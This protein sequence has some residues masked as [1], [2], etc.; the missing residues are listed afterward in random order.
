MGR[1]RDIAMEEEDNYYNEYDEDEEFM[2][3]VDEDYLEALMKRKEEHNK[4]FRRR[5]FGWIAS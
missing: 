4:K 5:G 1:R 2:D 3:F